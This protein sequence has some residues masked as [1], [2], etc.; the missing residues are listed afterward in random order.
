MFPA[1]FIS[2]LLV[3][4]H[5]HGAEFSA[6][7]AKSSLLA[8]VSIV[9]YA[10]VV[11]VTY[12]PLGIAMGTLIAAITSAITGYAMYRFVISRLN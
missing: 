11:R 9:M 3:A 6:S 8:A 4:Y 12:L 1:M 10:V 5:A 7:L 2:T